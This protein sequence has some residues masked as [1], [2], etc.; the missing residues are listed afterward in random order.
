M[1]LIEGKHDESFFQKLRRFG[2]N[3]PGKQLTL[4]V[5]A[6]GRKQ[7][8]SV[9]RFYFALGFSDVLAITDLEYIFCKEAENLLK[10]LKLD[11]S[12]V[13]RFRNHIHHAGEGDPKLEEIFLAWDK[14][15]EPAGF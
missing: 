8:R 14:Y 6:A 10:E 11:S 12:V 5:K 13:D 4:F 2:V 3:F 7:L 9:R 15:G 1:V